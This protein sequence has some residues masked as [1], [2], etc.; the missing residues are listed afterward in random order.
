VKK[1][2]NESMCMNEWMNMDTHVAQVVPN[3]AFS[4]SG[5]GFAPMVPILQ[6]I[7]WGEARGEVASEY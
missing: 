3:Q 4:Y 1:Y 5:R 6:F 2:L 7:N